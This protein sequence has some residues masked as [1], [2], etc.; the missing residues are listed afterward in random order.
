MCSAEVL[1]HI[2]LFKTLYQSIFKKIIAEINEG[3]FFGNIV[4]LRFGLNET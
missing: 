1:M 2:Y 4:M 3:F